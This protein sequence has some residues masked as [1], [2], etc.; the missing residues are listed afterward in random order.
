M[1]MLCVAFAGAM[2]DP[3]ERTRRDQQIIAEGSVPT[4]VLDTPPAI[5]VM[6][7]GNVSTDSQRGLVTP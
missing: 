1:W 3:S 2:K 7:E 6:D 5:D 4:V